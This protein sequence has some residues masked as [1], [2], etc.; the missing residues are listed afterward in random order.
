MII[1]HELF[2]QNVTQESR[3]LASKLVGR[4]TLCESIVSR[5]VEAM[6]SVSRPW[7]LSHGLD[8]PR[9]GVK[10]APGVVFIQVV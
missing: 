2:E 5:T 8:Q 6:E 1:G 7:R 9:S 3:D 10:Q 4:A